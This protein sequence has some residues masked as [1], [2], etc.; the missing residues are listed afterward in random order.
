[1]RANE[2]TDEQVTQSS[3]RLFLNH[4]AYREFQVLAN[5]TLKGADGGVFAP[6]G[7][8]LSAENALVSAA[9]AF[10]GAMTLADGVK[11]DEGRKFVIKQQVSRIIPIVFDCFAVLPF[12]GFIFSPTS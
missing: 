6:T 11:L 12:R 2:R 7:I 8:L 9:M 1:M 3:T 10:E 5:G 4:L